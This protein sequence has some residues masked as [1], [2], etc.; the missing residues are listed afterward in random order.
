MTA[1]RIDRAVPSCLAAVL[2]LGFGT[3][4]LGCSSTTSYCG[5]SEAECNPN[6][7]YNA[8]PSCTMLGY[9]TGSMTCKD[10]CTWD[11]SFCHNPCGEGTPCDGLPLEEYASCSDLGYA[12][13][14]YYC[15][16]SCEFDEERTS[17]NDC[18]DG[19]CG[20]EEMESGCTEDCTPL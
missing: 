12:A 6:W 8:P 3:S 1:Y 11:R 17:C 5:T 7:N 2:L 10:D 18:G 16:A 19:V 20:P 14:Q 9:Q 15:L 4:H 13:G